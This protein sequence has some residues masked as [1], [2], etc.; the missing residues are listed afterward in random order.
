LTGEQTAKAC[1]PNPKRYSGA[2]SGREF[3]S[4]PP[5]LLPL[6]ASLLIQRKNL[7]L[8]ELDG[9]ALGLERSLPSITMWV[10]GVHTSPV[11]RCPCPEPP[12]LQDLAETAFPCPGKPS[13]KD[14]SIVAHPSAPG[15][16]Q[17]GA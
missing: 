13:P 11:G 9:M 4:T 1:V 14:S 16:T 12:R 15:S 8:A 7:D 6:P 3:L 5:F 10:P 17:G 2:E